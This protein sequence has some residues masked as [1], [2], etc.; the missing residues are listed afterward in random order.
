[1]TQPFR[2]NKLIKEKS[3]YLLQYANT[4]VAWFPW[5]QEA[6]DLSISEDKPIFL[7]IG[8]MHSRLCAKMLTDYYENLE[9]VD[10]LNKYF[11]NVNVD[12]DELPHIAQFYQTL[13]RM[14][15]V[16]QDS[17]SDTEWPLNLILTSEG[18]PF[19]S[20]PYL[21]NNKWSLE[22]QSFSKLLEN[23]YAMW[24]NEEDRII[25]T[26]Q[27]R[28]AF[29]VVAFIEN[30]KRKELLDEAALKRAI[31]ALYHDVDAHFGG[32]NTFPK[33]IPALLLHFLFRCS[34]EYNDN[35]GLFFVDRSLTT[36]SHGG[37]FDH[38]GGGFYT[39][40]IDDKWLIPCFE[41]YLIENA[42][43]ALN[44]AEMWA[45]TGNEEFYFV[46]KQILS[47]LL[48]NL[49]EES[50]GSFFHSEQE[51][52][53]F[54]HDKHCE[55]SW[56]NK[57]WIDTLGHD[58]QI[59]C[60]YYGVSRE[61]LGKGNNILHIP[62]NMN[63][64]ILAEKHHMSLEEMQAILLNQKELFKQR[65]Q[66]F[67]V[68]SIN[69]LS[70]TCNNGW[71]V[72]VLVQIGK[73]FGD[74]AYIHIAEK[75]MQFIASQLTQDHH[76]FRRWCEG[77]SK[78]LGILKDYAAVMMGALAL[79][80]AGR[81]ARWLL[82]VE[83]LAVEVLLLFRSD[84]GIF[85]STD[86]RETLVLL[87]Q[88][89]LLDDDM[90]SGNALLSQVFLKMYLITQKKHY[91]IYTENILQFSQSYWQTQKLSALGSLIAAQKYFSRNHRKIFIS[92]ANELDR[93]QILF[94]LKGVFLPHTYFVWLTYQDKDLL[95]ILLPENEHV[96]IPSAQQNRSKIYLLSPEQTLIFNQ[97]TTFTDYLK[98][99]FA[100]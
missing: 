58:A 3:P 47:Y 87:R 79:F 75:T 67:S 41:K 57:E 27:S 55:G 11:V 78:Y 31:E 85:Y 52:D 30:S 9:V 60:D 5:S 4:P 13:A 89:D 24:S 23:L 82:Y 14:I 77:E 70:L 49:Y 63:L 69:D 83:E 34:V 66:D 8:H 54:F 94:N 81:G 21:G 6:F 88:T 20:L 19:F 2:T 99:D 16:S 29:E 97:I 12:K 74:A 53:G 46:S 43:M 95:K 61:H 96:L 71:M 86:Q 84:Q 64:R 73:L 80:E 42:S 76:V 28:K 93:E 36:M 35:R 48:S 39:Y 62:F 92:L 26:N 56:L 17:S 25:L 10:T 38:I 100:M 32:I 15:S 45:Y 40:S 68:T 37:V 90:I 7:S 22:K 98:Q 33:K 59:F 1:M 65:K 91:L 50:L 44:Y 51:E 18:F 72:F